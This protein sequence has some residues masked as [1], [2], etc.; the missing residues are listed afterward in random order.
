M[1]WYGGVGSSRGE[2]RGQ[3]EIS[4]RH[5]GWRTMG[6]EPPELPPSSMSGLSSLAFEPSFFFERFALRGDD[7]VVAARGDVAVCSERAV[8]AGAA[9]VGRKGVVVA[10]RVHLL[11]MVGSKKAGLVHLVKLVEVFEDK[12]PL[13]LL[14]RPALPHHK[15]QR[16]VGVGVGVGERGVCGNKQQGTYRSS[17]QRR[18]AQQAQHDKQPH[19][20][21]VVVVL[22]LGLGGHAM[23]STQPLPARDV[24]LATRQRCEQTRRVGVAAGQRGHKSHSLVVVPCL[25]DVRRVRVTTREGC[26]VLAIKI[27][28][29]RVATRQWCEVLHVRRVRVATRQRCQVFDIRRIGLATRERCQVRAIEVG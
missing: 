25:V 16:D 7:D 5:Q 21:V 1:C 23:P 12:I 29:V 10:L 14:V 9:G 17:K 13:V 27:R 24:R 15:L 22:H 2:G 3:R 28:R 19:P 6:G 4:V 26:Q 8:S 18:A 20:P 11:R